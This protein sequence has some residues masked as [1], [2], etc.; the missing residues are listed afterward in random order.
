M[1]SGLGLWSRRS[2]VTL[3][4]PEVRFRRLVDSGDARGLSF[5]TGTEWIEF[6]GRLED[7]HIATILP[8][9]IRGNH[10][11]LR[12]R[13]AIAV[14]FN[15]VWELAWDQGEGTETRVERFAGGGAVL[16]EV[17]P[18]ASH[19]IANTGREPLWIVGMSNGAWDA[20]VPDSFP[21]GLLPRG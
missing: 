11:H 9:A 8:G 16:L 6:L 20:D 3:S 7:A 10:Y 18:Q 4:L 12:R 14:L 19:A 1:V 21:R 17:E 2:E 5:Q 13:E 15:D